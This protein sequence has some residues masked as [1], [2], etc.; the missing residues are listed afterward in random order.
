MSNLAATPC[1]FKDRITDTFYYITPYDVLR[2]EMALETAL[3]SDAKVSADYWKAMLESSSFRFHDVGMDEE[4]TSGWCLECMLSSGL[5][6]IAFYHLQNSDKEHGL[7]FEIYTEPVPCEGF[8]MC[9][10]D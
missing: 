10:N 3:A 9:L 2:A 6:V 4:I 5:E 1:W 8:Q 7:Y